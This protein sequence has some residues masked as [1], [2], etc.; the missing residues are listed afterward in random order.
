MAT[1]V[2]S[3]ISDPKMYNCLEI[4]QFLSL[5][6]SFR[7]DIVM[8]TFLKE[9]GYF[10]ENSNPTEEYLRKDMF[11]IIE[12]NVT[13]SG[14]KTTFYNNVFLTKKGML[15]II[16]RVLNHRMKTETRVI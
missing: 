6:Y 10:D 8:D 5:I 3:Y 11:R 1:Y 14:C 13:T 12:T 7:G 16:S 15:A 4:R 2:T 9:A